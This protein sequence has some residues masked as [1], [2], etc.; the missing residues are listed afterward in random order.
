MIK[1]SDFDVLSDFTLNVRN[2]L[3]EC[4]K[5]GEREIVF[6]KNT[7]E[8][9]DSLA[10]ERYISVSNHSNGLKKILFLIDG[11]KNLTIDFCGS[12][13]NISGMLIPFAIINSK[14]IHIKNV[15]IKYTYPQTA[16]AVITKVSENYFEFKKV[17][18]SPI[19][20]LDNKLYSGTEDGMNSKIPYAVIFDKDTGLLAETTSGI[21]LDDLSFESG[22][23]DSGETIF[24]CNS[25]MFFD[26]KLKAGDFMGIGVFHRESCHIFI[27]HSHNIEIE[28]VSIHNGVGMGIIA[29]CSENIEVD[30]LRV[31]PDEGSHLAISADATHFVHCY[32]KIHIHNSYF[33]AMLDDALNVHGIYLRIVDKTEKSI[34]VKFMHKE[35]LGIKMI[36]EGDVI[37]TCNPLSLIAKKR[38]EV[39][40]VNIINQEYMELEICGDTKDI[41]IGDDICEVSKMPEVIFENCTVKNNRGRGMLLA[42]G[43]K[44]TIRKNVFSTHG[45]AIKL[46]SDGQFWFE[47]GAVKDLLISE[48]T[49]INCNYLKKEVVGGIVETAKK[50]KLE[51]GKYFHGKI[52][53]SNNKF[54][55]CNTTPAVINNAETFIFKNNTFENCTKTDNVVEYV[56]NI[57]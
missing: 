11:F 1:Y 21:Y 42:G 16:E 44:T 38:Y 57:Y 3:K 50:T 27:D 34:L 31:C 46:E 23:D 37:E 35:S 22:K 26:L 10:S 5:N 51:E 25:N 29:Q 32:G 4:A 43:G 48:N 55:D 6:E 56:K 14:N 41:I 8:V 2:M 19:Y 36:E 39:K 54:I 24:K 53:I 18:V 7:Y 20:V 17:G 47:S 9:S 28:N 33:T 40:K 12:V 45:S 49:F 15:T 52:E 13:L 30:N